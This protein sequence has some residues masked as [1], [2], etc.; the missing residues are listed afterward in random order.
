MKRIPLLLGLLLSLGATTVQSQA[1]PTGKPIEHV[2]WYKMT[3]LKFK[4]G[5]ADEARKLIYEHFWPVD[6]EIGR[7][8]IPFD[9]VTGDWDEVVFF[10]MP[11]GPSELGVQSTPWD[12]KWNESFMR[13]EGGK[14]KAQA[15]QKKFDDMVLQ[16]KTDVVMRRIS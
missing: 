2:A 8:V 15:L 7:E 13:R 12:A 9:P 3:Y 11:G 1:A 10:P 4:P 6:R 14:E 5:M 16:S